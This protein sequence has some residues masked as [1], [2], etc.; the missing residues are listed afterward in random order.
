MQN[1]CEILNEIMEMVEGKVGPPVNSSC[2]LSVKN[3]IHRHIRNPASM[4][5]QDKNA[6]SKG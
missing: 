1:F 3:I 5:I 6:K 4:K 2:V